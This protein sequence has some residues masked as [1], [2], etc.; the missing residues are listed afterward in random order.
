[1]RPIWA[2]CQYICGAYLNEICP[3]AASLAYLI[4]CGRA[5]GS[6]TPRG[7]HSK[8]TGL[9]KALGISWQELAMWPT[10]C[11]PQLQ[12]QP[13][14]QAGVDDSTIQALGRWGSAEC[15][16]TSECQ[17]TAWPVSLF[18]WHWPTDALYSLP[19]LP[20]CVFTQSATCIQGQPT[21]ST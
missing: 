8:R 9:S 16:V 11:R 20:P 12:N 2:W 15:L 19:P 5:E 1:M 3:V 14:Q 10:S 17:G 13:C 4:I 18:A 7:N 21:V 6:S